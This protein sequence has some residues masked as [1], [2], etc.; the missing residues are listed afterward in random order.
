M[1]TELC[2]K[3]MN[4]LEMTAIIKKATYKTTGNIEYKEYKV[5]NAK[6]IINEID[7]VL[8][9]HQVPRPK[10]STSSSTMTSN[11]VSATTSSPTILRK[12]NKDDNL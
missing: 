8:A 3:F 5:S 7:R 1:L 12:L 11:T 2:V 4:A 6:P 9:Q 10:N